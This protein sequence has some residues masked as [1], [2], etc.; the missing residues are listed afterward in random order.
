MSENGIYVEV[1]STQLNKLVAELDVYLPAATQSQ[2]LLKDG[3]IGP[4]T[5]KGFHAKIAEVLRLGMSAGWEK[6]T[7][8]QPDE[9]WAALLPRED[10][11]LIV[12]GLVEKAEAGRL[13]AKR[14]TGPS[15]SDVANHGALLFGAAECDRVAKRL[16]E[17]WGL[18]WI[19]H[20]EGEK[21]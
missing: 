18:K 2:A 10:L 9:Y 15:Q 13:M 17:A 6:A 19:G 7:G 20:R 16:C 3:P 8:Q 1:D 12:R 14:Y 11:V 4:G 21:R 5:L